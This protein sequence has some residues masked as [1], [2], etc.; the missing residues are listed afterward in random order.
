MK[1][2]I[3]GAA[4]SVHTQRWVE[5]LCERGH[6]VSLISQHIETSWTRSGA[7]SYHLLPWRSGLGYIG[8]ARALRA[9][10]K[11][12]RPDILN[13]HYAGGYGL[14]SR[15]SSYCPTLL[16]VYGADVYDV[17]EKSPIHKNIITKN[18]LA[19]TR[20][21]STSKCMEGRVRELVPN[22]AK[23]IY[24]TPFGVDIEKFR[25]TGS[26]LRGKGGTV[27]IGTVKALDFKY[28]IDILLRSFRL[29]MDR[30][31]GDNLRL[32]IV[33]GGP[34]E[35]KLKSQA[36]ALGL[37]PH[38]N[39]IGPVPHAEVPRWLNSFDIYVAASRLDS[40]SFGVSVIE[41]SACQ[42][43]VVVTDVGGLPEVVR[44]GLTGFVIPKDN[45][46]ALADRLFALIDDPAGRERL[47]LNGRSHV[48]S[49]YEWGHCLDV[50]ESSY[51]ATMSCM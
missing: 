30:R 32:V 43:P 49:N 21:A 19:P 35:A 14:L 34:L 25:P 29:L 51:R 8:N 6:Q 27:T 50:M 36:M 4:H 37:T 9:V 23:D 5:G 40:E 20:L 22:Y 42:L 24:I 13:T 33:G 46:V 44:D 3:L 45:P 1:V 38:V 39:F 17:P 31:P 18:L 48:C 11:S 41:A 47:G 26:T 2:A 7:F 15:L 12:I 28:G 16:S 10:L